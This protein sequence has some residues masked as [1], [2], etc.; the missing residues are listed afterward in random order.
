[1]AL[2]IN[3]LRTAFAAIFSF[4]ALIPAIAQH[5]P[6]EDPVIL[7][8]KVGVNMLPASTGSKSTGMDPNMDMPA[9]M[10]ARV[11]RYESKAYSSSSSDILTNSDVVTTATASGLKKAC[12]QEIGSNTTSGASNNSGF[13]QYG[14][15]GQPQ[16]VV[17][18]GD[19]VNICK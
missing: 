19:L 8:V 5:A 6:G 7:T 10:R 2:K 12:V 3:L 17:L 4:W 14:P 9:W 13:A 11:T 16:V 1:M 18:K 15:K